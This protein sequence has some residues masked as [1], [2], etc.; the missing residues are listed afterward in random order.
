MLLNPSDNSVYFHSPYHTK[1]QVK[2]QGDLKKKK[3]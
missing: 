2:E 1:K 3:K